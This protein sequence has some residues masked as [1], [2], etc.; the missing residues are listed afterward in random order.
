MFPS[1]SCTT[2]NFCT[3]WDQQT[4]CRMDLCLSFSF[5][6]HPFILGFVVAAWVWMPRDVVLKTYHL[7]ACAR[8]A[9][10]R[11]TMPYTYGSSPNNYGSYDQP[12]RAA[13]HTFAIF[14][15]LPLRSSFQTHQTGPGQA[16]CI[17][18][19]L[20]RARLRFLPSTSFNHIF[21]STSE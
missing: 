1:H 5:H 6:G 11:F 14:L 21:D 15:Q 12:K 9:F 7:S 3:E 20:K 18:S 2:P 8:V 4:G 17:P 19:L 16:P 13:N 10:N